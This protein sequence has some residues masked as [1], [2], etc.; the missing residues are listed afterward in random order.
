MIV[1]PGEKKTLVIRMAAS[2]ITLQAFTPGE[3]DPV[4]PSTG[5]G[6]IW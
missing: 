2:R 4:G 3:S 5:D 1:F 6:V